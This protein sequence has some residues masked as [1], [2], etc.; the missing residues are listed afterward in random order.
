MYVLREYHFIIQSCVRTQKEYI[1]MFLE[2]RLGKVASG[3]SKSK[4]KD[5]FLSSPLGFDWVLENDKS[6]PQQRSREARNHR[7]HRLI[8]SRRQQR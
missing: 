8:L 6:I 2:G 4:L 1:N 3:T 7:H 5:P